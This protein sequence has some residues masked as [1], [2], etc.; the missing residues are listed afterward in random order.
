MWQSGSKRGLDAAMRLL[1]QVARRSKGNF[2]DAQRSFSGVIVGGGVTGCAMLYNLAKRGVNCVLF[3]KGELTCGATWHAA[4]LVTRFHG[5]NNFRL[6][7]DEGVDTFRQWQDEGTPLSFHTPGSIRLV[8]DEK[9]YIDEVKYQHGKAKIFSSLFSCA[10]HH[11]ISPAEIKE[12]HPLVNLEG[13]GIYCGLL[14]EGD[15]HIDPSSVTNAFADRAKGLGGTI[16]TQTE[17]VGLSLLPD[18]RW[19]VITRTSKGEEKRTVADF[20]VNAAGLWC[21]VVGRMA[22]VRVPSVV[23]QHQY[24]ITE[25]IDEV[26]EFHDK[27]GHQL[28]VLRDLKGSFY[29]RDERDGILVGPY[30]GSDVVQLAPSEWR[31]TGMPLD[32]AN[33]LFE[34]DVERLMPHLER[35]MEIL[36]QVGEVGMKT[37]LN[38]PTMWP[39]DGNHLVGPA[40]EWDVAPNF[41]LACA[42]SYGIAHSA[43][44]SRYLAEWIVHGEPP[45]ELKEAD[46]ARYGAWAT[47]DWVATKVK[48]TYG[49]NN[50]THFPNEQ[51]PAGR[52]VEPLPNKDIYEILKAQGCQF[53]FHNGWESANYF[54]PASGG[55]Q[56]GNAH[57]SF[58]RPS[59]QDLIAQECKDMANFGGICYWP[60]AKYHVSGPGAKAFMDNLVPNRVPNVGRCALSYFLT[61]QG[62]I[63][64]EVMLARIS[65]DRFYVISYPE[66]EWF[67]WRWMHMHKPP[68]GVTIENVTA[69]FGTLMVSG[70]ESRRVLGQLAGDEEAWSKE[71]FKFYAWKEV[72]IAG[73]PCRALRVSFTGE[74]GWELHPATADVAPL[75]K[76]LKAFEPRLC[77][78]GGFAMGSFRLEKGFKAFGSD[79]TRDHHALEAGISGKFLRMEKDFIGRDALLACQTPE[80]RLVH[81]AVSSPEGTDCVGNE[82]IFDTSTGK[83]VGFTTSGGYGYLAKQSIA[84]GY[85][86]SATL[87]SGAALAVEVLGEQYAARVQ[88]GAFKPEGPSEAAEPASAVR[89]SQPQE[90]RLRL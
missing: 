72:E 84:F 14:T 76:A 58:H 71:N 32:H 27:H 38:G 34:G 13:N 18:K 80:R 28:P 53:G 86:A 37:V 35:A 16:E 70:P 42:E 65:E 69:D 39:A 6:W 51:L 9:G 1:P 10:E 46:P 44:L 90:S 60:F 3:E 4:G 24:C 2:A 62:K 49:M 77:D 85:V 75:Y 81:L 20:V 87:D 50:H 56:H 61:P 41:W 83:V 73:I 7:H 68:E 64:S 30:E 55:D 88:E 5:G 31:Q 43:G 21:D 25:G 11:M 74:L 59:Y 8:P 23:L 29:V 54:D 89:A 15:G 52:P 17:V 26:K 57:G 67:D 63:G 45:Y 48:E 33:F 36:P 78:W 66:Q 22:G 12:R 40:P 19:E 82:A 47:K 79:M